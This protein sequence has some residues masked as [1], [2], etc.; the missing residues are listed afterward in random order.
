MRWVRLGLRL[1]VGSGR[2]GLLRAALMSAGAALGV[3]VVLASL[4]T[5]SVASAQ[6]RRAEARTPVHEK[7]GTNG[8]RMIEIDDAIGGR[9][10]RRTVVAGVTARAPRPPGLAAYPAPG[11]VVVSPALAELIRTD[12][13]AGDLRREIPRRVPS[14]LPLRD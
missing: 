11:Q 5:V 10:L 2:V 12:P 3:F 1:S 8:L 7:A 14:G 13:R 4:A 9:P 6:L